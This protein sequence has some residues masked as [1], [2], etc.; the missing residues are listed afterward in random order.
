MSRDREFPQ[1][2]PKVCSPVCV[3]VYFNPMHRPEPIQNRSVRVSAGSRMPRCFL[4]VICMLVG[5]RMMSQ[6][7]ISVNVADFGAKGDAV[8]FY[9]NTTAGS[10]LVTTTNKLSTADIGKTI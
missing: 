5:L 6:A 3:N 8:Q 1:N 4:L 10:A 9:V 7:Q 2:W